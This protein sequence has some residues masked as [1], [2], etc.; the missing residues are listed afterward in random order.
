MY[1]SLIF[2]L[3]L[4][5]LTTATLAGD[6]KVEVFGMEPGKNVPEALKSK[7]NGK[8]LKE[9]A[10]P[11]ADF[12]SYFV[13]VMPKG[14][15]YQIDFVTAMKTYENGADGK[16]AYKALYDAKKEEYG[17]E[18]G[19]YF[20]ANGGRCLFTISYRAKKLTFRVKWRQ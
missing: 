16:A 7:V 9:V 12:D 18:P 15:E 17:V 2:T 4:T 13:M 3:L 6:K 10:T 19:V 8:V 14:D 1:K 11:S 20:E 5:V